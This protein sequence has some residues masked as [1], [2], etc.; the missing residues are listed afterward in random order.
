MKGDQKLW[1]ILNDKLDM[2]R[3][4]NRLRE[5][6]RVAETALTLAQRAFQP[7]DPNYT[8]SLE[9]IGQLHDQAG[10]RAAA[11]P[12]LV[13]AHAF[14]EKAEPRDERALFRSARRLGFVCD[15]LGETEAALEYYEGAF[16]AGARLSDIPYSD[17]GTILNNVALIYRKTGRQKAAEPYYLHALEIYEKQLG[18]EHPDVASVLNNLAVFYTNERRFAEAEKTHLRALAIRE[19]FHPPTHPDIAQSKCNLAV[20]YHSNGDYARASELYRA[21][22]KTWEAATDKPPEDYEIVASNYADLL[23]SLGKARQ[24]NQ[25]EERARKRRRSP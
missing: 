18:P 16:K 21:S 14:L 15:N 10:D 2:L 19:K 5:A 9:K 12:Y 4:S 8:L 25:I 11:K 22:I 7:G 3:A 24:A 1:S 20:V 6:I 17:L 23:R 13:K